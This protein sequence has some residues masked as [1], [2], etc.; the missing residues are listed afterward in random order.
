VLVHQEWNGCSG[1]VRVKKGA[2]VAE[3]PA[4]DTILLRQA[5]RESYFNRA[6]GIFVAAKGVLRRDVA[7]A[8]ARGPETAQ[9]GAAKEEGISDA[10]I[11]APKPK[12]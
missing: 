7:G 12:I 1:Q 9:G 5:D 3:N 2:E 11:L 10:D 8:D 4:L 6:A